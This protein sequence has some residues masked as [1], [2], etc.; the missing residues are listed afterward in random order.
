MCSVFDVERIAWLEEVNVKRHKIASRS[1]YEGELINALARTQKP[2]LASL[3]MWKEDTF[4]VIEN[5][6]VDFL[7]C[8]SKYPTP[9][10]DVKLDSIDFSQYIGF[11][12]HTIGITAPLVAITKGAKIIEKHFT[13]DKAMYGPDHEGSMTPEELQ[14][15]STF[16]DE[17]SEVL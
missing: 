9:L 5:A 1:I 8:I 16:R 4:P 12:D 10:Q 13:L 2:I 7:Y 14:A 6:D 11:S 15:L 3:G 17:Y